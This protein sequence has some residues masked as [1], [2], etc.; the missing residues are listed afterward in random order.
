MPK[1]DLKRIELCP[2]CGKPW[3][4]TAKGGYPTRKPYRSGKRSI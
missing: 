3:D 1:F 4:I 2:A